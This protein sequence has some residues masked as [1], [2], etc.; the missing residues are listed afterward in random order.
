MAESFVQIPDDTG[1]DGKK[2]RTV[3]SEQSGET[4]HEHVV[5]V[6][7]F[8]STQPVSAA[9]LP[10]PSGAATETSVAALTKPADVQHASLD[11]VCVALHQLFV[12]L[13]RPMWINTTSQLKCAVESTATIAALTTVA[14]VTNLTNFNGYDSKLAQMT[15]TWQ[16]GV[17]N[18]IA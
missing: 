2:M 9:A 8:P 6:S 3:T 5:E 13:S 17:R 11:D 15:Q 12:L 1:N 18:R 7:N 16:L 10:L 4:V 14:T